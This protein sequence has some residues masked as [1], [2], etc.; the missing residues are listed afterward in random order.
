M[1]SKVSAKAP[2]AGSAGV[3]S[4]EGEAPSGPATVVKR[5]RG[6]PRG[7]NPESYLPTF[8]VRV[9]QETHDAIRAM[10]AADKTSVASV[11]RRVIT[12]G[13]RADLTRRRGQ[14]VR[15]AIAR[16]IED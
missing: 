1:S 10:A 13:L 6:R 14:P 5:G 9:D 4:M 16:A 12:E 2:A 3:G 7:A 8:S 11:Y 15:A